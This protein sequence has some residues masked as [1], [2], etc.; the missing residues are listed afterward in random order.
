MASPLPTNQT[1]SEPIS[2]G[3]SFES[4]RDDAIASLC[5]SLRTPLTSSMGFLQLALRECRRAEQVSPLSRNLELADEQLRRL[6]AMIEEFS[7]RASRR[8]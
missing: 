1:L 4:Q 5:H 7:Q 2:A 6:A 8:A 3:S